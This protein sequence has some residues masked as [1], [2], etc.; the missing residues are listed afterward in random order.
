MTPAAN[1]VLEVILSG[2][3]IKARINGAQVISITDASYTGMK[4][5]IYGQAAGTEMDDFSHTRATA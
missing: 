3:A 4:H 1:D 5:G 2:T